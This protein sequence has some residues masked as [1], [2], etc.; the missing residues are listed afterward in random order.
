[1][2]NEESDGTEEYIETDP[3]LIAMNK[4]WKEC[5]IPVDKGIR[6][7]DCTNK[8]IKFVKKTNN[9][10][11]NTIVVY[12]TDDTFLILENSYDTM[13]DN[14]HM[15]NLT[16]SETIQDLF[17]E[18]NLISKEKIDKYRKFWKD[19]ADKI[20]KEIDIKKLRELL[21]KY[22]DFQNY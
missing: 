21:I 6:L 22:P 2:E 20:Q 1:M 4:I 7:N 5:N 10:K 19:R 16:Q 13:N 12:F 17:I 15:L 8:I 3:E 11:N 18:C 14:C 9:R